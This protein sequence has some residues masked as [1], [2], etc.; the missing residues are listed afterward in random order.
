M[1]KEQKLYNYCVR[2]NVQ[3]VK[4]LLTQEQEIDLTFSNGVYFKIAI[5]HE[6]AKILRILLEHFTKSNQDASSL[7]D[8]KQILS[9][10]IQDH[11]VPSY[12]EDLV[13]DYITLDKDTDLESEEIYNRDYPVAYRHILERIKLIFNT[14]RNTLYLDKV[15][16]LPSIPPSLSDI[17]LAHSQLKILQDKLSKLD[18]DVQRS[19]NLLPQEGK[20]TESETQLKTLK[21]ALEGCQL[22]LNHFITDIEL[23]SPDLIHYDSYSTEENELHLSG[24]GTLD[25]NTCGGLIS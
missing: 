16:K 10:I 21:W 12:I 19:I 22:Y 24:D 25:G 14:A 18:I 7:N 11:E 5:K 20:L 6:N 3:G 9:D 4:Q 23:Q 13:N 1:E 8:L 15:E 17:K 2:D